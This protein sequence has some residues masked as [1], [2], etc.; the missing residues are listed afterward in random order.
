MLA[1]AYRPAWAGP[2][3]DVAPRDP[4]DL[5]RMPDSVRPFLGDPSMRTY[6]F[7]VGNKPAGMSTSAPGM[8]PSRW[9]RRT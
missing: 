8:N 3:V 7:G 1:V 9:E 4:A 2:I 6:E 5:E